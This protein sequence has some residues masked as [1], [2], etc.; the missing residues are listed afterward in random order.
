MTLHRY[1]IQIGSYDCPVSIPRKSQSLA[2]STFKTLYNYPH[3]R[4][5]EHPRIVYLGAVENTPPTK[6]KI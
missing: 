5:V 6:E 2:W 1:I 3:G 4:L